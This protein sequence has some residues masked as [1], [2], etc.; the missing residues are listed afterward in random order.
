MHTILTFF[1]DIQQI[2]YMGAAM[3]APSAALQSGLLLILLDYHTV[4]SHV[5]K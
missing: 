2:L 3:Y 1:L 5:D 4:Y